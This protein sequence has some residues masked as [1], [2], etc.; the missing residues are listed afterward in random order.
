METFKCIWIKIDCWCHLL[1]KLCTSLNCFIFQHSD[2]RWEQNVSCWTVCWFPLAGWR[3]ASIRVNLNWAKTIGSFLFFSPEKTC[4][5]DL[6][7]WGGTINQV[8]VNHQS[9]MCD[10]QGLISSGLSGHW[11]TTYQLS[12]FTQT[13]IMCIFILEETPEISISKDFVI[14]VLLQTVLISSICLV[15]ASSGLFVC[16]VLIWA[17]NASQLLIKSLKD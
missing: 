4:W 7:N 2:E 1:V 15:S 10:Q 8:M 14:I 16:A 17:E 6:M 13:S 3:E 12:V 11:L 9:I 5:R